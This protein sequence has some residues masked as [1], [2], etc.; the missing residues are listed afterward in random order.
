MVQC[1][2]RDQFVGSPQIRVEQEFITAS[3]GFSSIFLYLTGNIPADFP[4]TLEAAS[5]PRPIMSKVGASGI[6][7][8]KKPGEIQKNMG[9]VVMILMI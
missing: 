7:H 4:E 8:R 9:D 6:F 5:A 3:V 2:T 1:P